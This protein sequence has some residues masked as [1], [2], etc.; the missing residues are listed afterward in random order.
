MS[1]KKGN[2]K[3][4][5]LLGTHWCSW[6]VGLD[7]FRFGETHLACTEQTGSVAIPKVEVVS[8]PFSV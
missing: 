2:P 4:G 3:A 8:L 6:C 1:W 5:R 7:R